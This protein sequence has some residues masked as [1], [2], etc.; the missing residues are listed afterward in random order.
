MNFFIQFFSVKLQADQL[1]DM[2]V[3]ATMSILKVERAQKRKV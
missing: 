3:M 2:T 1:D